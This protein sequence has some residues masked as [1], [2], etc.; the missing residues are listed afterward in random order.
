MLKKENG[1][2]SSN[3]PFY[4]DL[5]EPGPFLITILLNNSYFRS[6]KLFCSYSGL[7]SQVY[8]YISIV[9]K[10]W[11]GFCYIMNLINI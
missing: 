6:W 1:I 2:P 4:P 5:K 9:G 7:N 3:H 8:V 10:M 11:N